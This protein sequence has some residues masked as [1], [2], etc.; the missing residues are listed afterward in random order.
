MC[1]AQVRVLVVIVVYS[2]MY[3]TGGGMAYAFLPVL[4]KELEEFVELWNSHT[5]RRTRLAAS[6]C[7]RPDDLY[8][9]P[10]LF[11]GF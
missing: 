4:K 8:D 3:S 6:P 9:M 5:I 1:T 2:C 10:M 11:G 7:G